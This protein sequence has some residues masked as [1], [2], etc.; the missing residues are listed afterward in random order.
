MR[1]R[2][3]RR[4]G[5]HDIGE[6]GASLLTRQSGRVFQVFAQPRNIRAMGRRRIFEVEQVHIIGCGIDLA[7]EKVGVGRNIEA[8]LRQSFPHFLIV[9]H[10]GENAGVSFAFIASASPAVQ[11][12]FERIILRGTPVGAK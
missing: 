9:G 5:R 3:V 12:G 2:L 8:I 1:R 11:R 4:Q 10:H 7:G 6:A